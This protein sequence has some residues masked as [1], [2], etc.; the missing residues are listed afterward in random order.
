LVDLLSTYFWSAL[1]A[2]V[3]R[4]LP[5]ADAAWSKVTT[6]VTN[7][8]TWSQGFADDPRWGAYP[9]NKS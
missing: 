9:R 5:G 4:G 7:L 8:T 2:G 3:E 1:V 6:N